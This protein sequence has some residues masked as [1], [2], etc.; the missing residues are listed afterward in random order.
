[1][2]QTWRHII[3]CNNSVSIS[4]AIIFFLLCSSVAGQ[5]DNRNKNILILHSFGRIG[6]AIV[7]WD[8]GLRSAL[9]E[10]S[11][12]KITINIEHL[13][14]SRFNNPDYMK[15]MAEIFRYKYF[16][17]KPDLIFTVYEPSFNFVIKY[18]QEAFPNVPV[19][20][21]GIEELS[22]DKSK[23]PSNIT[24]VFQGA[25]SFG[26]TLD[27][28]LKLHPETKHIE[29]VSGS[30]YMELSWLEP[31]KKVFDDYKEK[32]E[33]KYLTGKPINEIELELANLQP[34]S[35]VLYFPV[36][37]DEVGKS[38]V[39]VEVLSQIS[40]ISSAPIYTFWDILLGSGAVGGYMNN[41][42]Q[43]A[44]TAA[45]MGLQIL[46]GTQPSEIIA[47]P[48]ENLKFIFDWRQLKRW[49]I[50]EKKLPPGSEIKFREYTFL[51]ENLG[52]IIF[53]ALL[54]VAQSLIITYLLIQRR[55]RR[56]SQIKL[57]E[58]ERK[59]RTVADFTYDWEYWLNS[60]GKMEYV[61][62]SCKRISGYDTEAF[63][64]NPSLIKSIVIPE[65]IQI[66]G[67]HYCNN[68]NKKI[69]E[70]I[71]FRIRRKDGEIRWL[72]HS[73]QP[74]IDSMGN[75]FGIRASNRDITEREKYK[76]ET[77]KLQSELAH[78]ERV[79]TVSTLT[80]A[81]AHEINQPLSS[82]RSY[83]QAAL[84]FMD[85]GNLEDE[86]IRKALLGIVDDNKR[87]TSV[88]DHLRNLVKKEGEQI[89]TVNI[90]SLITNVLEIVNSE[91]VLRNSSLKL[92]LDPGISTVKADPI[93]I[94][95][96]ILNLITNALDAMEDHSTENSI[97]T[98]TTEQSQTEGILITVSDTGSGIPEDELEE[99]FNP[100]Q[101]SKSWGLGLGLA[102]CKSIIEAH[103]GKIWAENKPGDGA[104]FSIY[105]PTA[106]N[107]KS[108]K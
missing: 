2:K 27:L 78:M 88:V 18:G 4:I 56:Q 91:L 105:L 61:S 100:F 29:V 36:L 57:M 28:V 25:N 76:S 80:Y 40:K 16:D 103:G 41:F 6:P 49:S 53:I 50:S 86:N 92:N 64:D 1:M 52:K 69:S 67:N 43:Q 38:Y 98:L 46:N 68:P 42:R 19:V 70:G 72:E 58:T 51:E 7:Q 44:L 12:F 60:E 37:E 31:A 5:D 106:W 75:Y 23:L 90:N 62:P 3:D 14:L 96:V 11:E 73:C 89:E 63:M 104:F 65:D 20:F 33:F 32:L 84:R 21:G 48:Q 59:Y 93:Q 35:I 101:S 66:W 54:I 81:L 47:S 97:I 99:I 79:V 30:G 85:K 108:N 77:N 39:P 83:A 24:G 13:D 87:A 17:H 107:A 74:I 82:I 9:G 10:Q 34:N 15:M 95:Q 8:N 55:L 71:Q 94:Q 102:I 22:I 26:E 45:D